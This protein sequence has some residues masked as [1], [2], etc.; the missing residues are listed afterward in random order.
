MPRLNRRAFLKG[1]GGF[2]VAGLAGLA[3]AAPTPAA[4][5][6]FSGAINAAD[7]GVTPGSTRDQG[8]ALAKLLDKSAGSGAPVFLPPGTYS[9]SNI[10][11]PARARLV[12]VSGATRL[13]YGGDGFLLLAED[14]EHI[15]LSGLVLD[16][17]HRWI[18][19]NAQGLQGLA[20]FR[21]VRNLVIDDCQIVDS[22]ANGLALEAVSGRIERS[23]I[24]GAAESGIYSVEAGRLSITGNSVTDCGNGGILVHRWQAADDFTMVSGNRI[25]RIAARRGGTGPYGNGINAFRADKVMIS[26][27]MIADCAFSAIRA[28]SASDVQI[29]GNSCVRSGETAIYSEFAFQGAVIGN[30]IVDGAANGISVV[31]FD[32]NGRLAV[33]TG[34]LVRN[35]TDVGPYTYDRPIF[36]VGISV[37][38]DTSVTGNVVE[39][40]ARYGLQLGWGPYLRNVSATGNVIRK[41]RTGIAVTVVEGAGA[42]LIAD[43]VIEGATDG[44]IVGFRW[45]DRA[46][47]DMAASGNPGY[48]HLTIE[49]NPVR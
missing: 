36:G 16:G 44:A 23:A 21:R 31:N 37:E 10:R 15:E 24:S 8:K 48:D 19:D 25:E 49:R 41:A 45:T 35:I 12:G 5:T 1:S 6:P 14:A 18:A 30:N 22:G 28:N 20:A 17:A 11:L 26:G 33:C 43:N 39:Q 7:A 42:A 38:A 40:V 32:Q 2:A 27:N 47:G 34:N 9:F 3:W 4:A 29:T 46:T 13:L